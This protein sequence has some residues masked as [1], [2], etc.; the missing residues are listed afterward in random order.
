MAN[1]SQHAGGGNLYPPAYTVYDGVDDD[2]FFEVVP[3]STN[4]ITASFGFKIGSA[5]V[6]QFVMYTL[7]TQVR[8]M[9]VVVPSTDGNNPN[10]MWVRI[11][12]SSGTT[13]CQLYS[14]DAVTDGEW[15][16]F[17]L[18]F[19]GDAGTAIFKIDG[20]DADNVGATGRVAPT[21]GTLEGSQDLI[22]ANVQD[23]AGP[24]TQWGAMSLT[25][26]VYDDSYLT[27][28]E[29]FS[30]GSSMTQL[31]R[32]D[33]AE[34]GGNQPHIYSPAGQ[35]W[36][37]LGSVGAPTSGNVT[38]VVIAS[39]S[40]GLGLDTTATAVAADIMAGR[41]AWV[42]GERV[43]GKNAAETHLFHLF[44]GAA[45]TSVGSI[46]P[47][48]IKYPEAWLDISA[49]AELD[50][51][52]YLYNTAAANASVLSYRPEVAIAERPNVRFVYRLWGKL[53]SA[54][55][56]SGYTPTM[57]T[58]AYANGV[59]DDYT[60][61]RMLSYAAGSNKIQAFHYEAGSV[62]NIY[63]SDS[64]VT[65]DGSPPNIRFEMTVVDEGDLMFCTFAYYDLT[66][67]S[68]QHPTGHESLWY[69]Q[70]GRANENYLGL[71]VSQELTYGLYIRGVHIFTEPM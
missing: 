56:N 59:H 5:T 3:D 2:V 65:V 57:R 19:D 39:V 33:W 4:K 38:E 53:T 58:N 69:N 29:D 32:N 26:V 31:D 11:K 55:V 13:L 20:V 46:T 10:K 23:V 34:F 47:T 22:L 70:A 37:N 15:H 25:E 14:I 36:D 41:S 6:N 50:G 7:L 9:A 68:Q 48:T 60:S 71:T 62:S 49:T 17:F 45:G 67:G 51:N 54:F 42:N 16:S 21:T 27:N 12:D 43:V 35:G 63:T 44:D 1:L 18:A 28:W 61:F 40:T 8:F 64:A 66:T 30:S 24:S 52:G